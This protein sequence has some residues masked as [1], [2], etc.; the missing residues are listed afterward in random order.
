MSNEQDFSQYG[1]YIPGYE[2]QVHY[3]PHMERAVIYIKL[4]M[5]A[6]G[7]RLYKA[8]KHEHYFEYEVMVVEPMQEPPVYL[9]LGEQ[10]LDAIVAAVRPP[11]NPTLEHLDDARTVRD[12][13]LT[14]VEADQIG[15]GGG[16]KEDPAAVHVLSE[17]EARRRPRM[18]VQP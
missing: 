14:L 13:L 5:Y 6:S 9:V 12:R 2:V 10:E 15:R 11:H 3:E 18:R 1:E 17:A 8:R 4:G 16:D 7:H